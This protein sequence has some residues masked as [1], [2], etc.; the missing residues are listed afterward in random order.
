MEMA[1]VTIVGAGLSGLTAAINLARR[2]HDVVV[3]ERE[4]R[5]GGSPLYHPSGQGSPLKLDALQSYLGFE[6][7]PGIE[8]IRDMTEIA[9]GKALPIDPS[10]I[11]SYFFERGPR[12]TSL[13]TYL[14]EVAKEAGVEFRF[15]N[16]V[17]SQEDMAQ[18]PPNTIVATGLH[19][20]G[21]DALRVPYLTSY[22]FTYKGTCDPELNYVHMFHDTYTS[23]YGY[24]S[25]FRGIRY[26]HLFNRREPISF[27]SRDRFAEHVE[28]F[29]AFEVPEW[30]QFTFPVPAA[31]IRT[32]RI[33][34]GSKIL[35]GTLAGAMDPVAFFGLNGALV[36]GKIAAIAVEDKERGWREFQKCVS[37]FPTAYTLSRLKELQP[38][39]LSVLGFRLAFMNFDRLKLVQR[40]MVEG[41]PGMRCLT[42]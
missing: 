37:V 3:L 40:I 1:E 6:I 27:S 8:P 10:L 42:Y 15:N 20:E 35:A 29:D 24:T 17:M 22:H 21:F 39:P 14:Y 31:T 13:D 2:G 25:A 5:I 4:E 30:N 7:T 19:F 12:S 18:L 11:N 41:V 32:P 38:L 36:S 23:D 28:R 34:V 26:V 16:P 33:F 9:G